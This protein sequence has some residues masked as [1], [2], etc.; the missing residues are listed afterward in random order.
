MHYQELIRQSGKPFRDY[1][2]ER[3]AS[4]VVQILLYLL[5]SNILIMSV[6]MAEE[7]AS[8]FG[9]FATLRL[10]LMAEG[11][12]FAVMPDGQNGLLVP[13][14]RA[15]EER[16][17]VVFRGRKVARI[18]VRG[19][20]ATGVALEDGTEISARA[21]AVATGTKRVP[22]LL[23]EIPGDVQAAVDYSRL[24]ASRDACVYAVLNEPV[25]DLK[26]FTAYCDE[27]GNPEA[28]L[29]P[30]HAIAPWT[31]RPGTQTLITQQTLPADQFDAAGGVEGVANRLL[32]LNDELFPGFSRAL[33][34]VEI[35]SNRHLWMEQFSHGPKLPRRADDVPGLWFVG[36]G[37][38]PVGIATEAAAGSG[39]V[40]A[41][42]IVA[43]SR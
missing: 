27:S 41:G 3:D 2:A 9:F 23:D 17:G 30:M 40:G 22:A 18:L 35:G 38:A 5:C 4:P 43:A 11:V 29:Y 34:G 33:E 16:G 10:W 28:F 6:E 36:D 7:H 12:S 25:V 42:E 13:M 37:T 14:A 26:T 20:T 31:S 15:I 19:G 24:L 39:V 8:T 21:V 1:L 32:K